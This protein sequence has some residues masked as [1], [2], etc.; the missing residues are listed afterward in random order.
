MDRCAKFCPQGLGSVT[1]IVD[2]ATAN[3]ADFR[4]VF[5]YQTVDGAPIDVTGAT[6]YMMLRFQAADATAE[7][8]LTTENGR[9][10]VLDA[11]NGQF[12][13]IVLQ[14]DLEQLA[15]AAYQQSLI[16]STSGG[17]LTRIW[18]GTFTVT[19]GPSR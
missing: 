12:E 19:I 4:R 15:A 17:A 2:I 9:I 11:P 5:N 3:D 6:F 14:A 7:F 1:A 13:L 18:S 10:V 16:M 8:E